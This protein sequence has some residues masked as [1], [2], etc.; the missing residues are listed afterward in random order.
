MTL[1]R[2]KRATISGPSLLPATPFKGAIDSNALT[3]SSDVKSPQC[4]ITAGRCAATL[5]SAAGKRCAKRGTCVSDTMTMRVT[6]GHCAAGLCCGPAVR[7]RLKPRRAVGI[8]DCTNCVEYGRRAVEWV[9]EVGQRVLPVDHAIVACR[10]N[11]L[12]VLRSTRR[13]TRCNDPA[14]TQRYDS[15]MNPCPS[16]ISM[17]MGGASGSAERLPCASDA[18]LTARADLSA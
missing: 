6:S 4:R 8:R 2:P 12:H 10:R 9:A 16:T 5:T 13:C 15:L 1:R 14:T 17:S 7:A 3:T 11:V 18:N